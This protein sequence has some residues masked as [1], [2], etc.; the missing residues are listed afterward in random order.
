MN[1]GIDDL[2]SNERINFTAI[3]TGELELLDMD[4]R[5]RGWNTAKFLTTRE[6]IFNIW[7]G[8]SGNQMNDDHQAGVDKYYGSVLTYLDYVTYAPSVAPTQ[9]PTPPPT[10]NPS[11]SPTKNPATANKANVYKLGVVIYCV[12]VVVILFSL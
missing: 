12:F 2:G 5:A 7:Y 1:T 4:A 3:R 9:P 6:I 11:R 10:N 8:D